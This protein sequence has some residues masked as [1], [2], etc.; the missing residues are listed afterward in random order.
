MGSVKKKR[1]DKMSHHK[2]KK[3]IKKTRWQRRKKK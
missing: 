1:K 2:H 3:R